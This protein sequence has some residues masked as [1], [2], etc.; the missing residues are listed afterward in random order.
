MIKIQS[1]PGLLIGMALLIGLLANPAPV[2]ASWPPLSIEI[3]PLYQDGKITYTIK[4]ARRVEGPLTDVVVKIPLPEGTRFLKAGAQPTTEVS[5]DGAEIT[6]FTSVLHRP[7]RNAYF[8]VETTNPNQNIFNTR[9]WLAW[10]G[11]QPGSYLIDDVSLDLSRQQLDWTRPRSRLRLEAGATVQ[12]NVI[13]YLLYPKNIGERRM[14]DL[15]VTIPLPQGTTLL[16]TQAPPPFVTDFNGQEVTFSTL[17]LARRVEVDPLIIQVSAKDVPDSQLVTQAWATWKNVGRRVG[18]GVEPQE[19]TSSGNIIVHPH[20]VQQVTADRTNDVPFSNYDLTGIALQE[21]GTV[22]QIRF[23]TVEEIG[24]VGQPLEYILYI[25]TDC[26][27]DTGGKRG[28]RGAE[29]WVRYMHQNGKAKIYRWNEAENGWRDAQPLESDYAGGK[30]V[31]VGVPLDLLET[32]PQLCW[33]GRV[34]NRTDTFSTSLP[35]EWVGVDPRL[36]EYKTGNKSK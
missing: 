33:L 5:F 2:R 15:Q 17:E 35:N 19:W 23:H 4:F 30:T 1:G 10:K 27:I 24:P 11:N 32:G 22:F 9:A 34:R 13:T 26:R 16:T 8:V 36:T 21:T 3:A 20:T 6:F 31:N 25:D 14:W 29:Y 12:N 7:V 18:R 28:N